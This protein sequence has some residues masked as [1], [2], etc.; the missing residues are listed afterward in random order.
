M[1]H[2]F[3]WKGKNSL[4]DF[5]LWI[6]KLPKITRPSERY[7]E[8]TIPGRAGT[9]ITLEGEDVYERYLKECVV[10]LPSD[11]DLQGILDWLRGNGDVVFSNEIDKAYTGRIAG[12][13]SFERIGNTL[14]QAT[15][16]FFVE[17]FK[18][19]RTPETIS[20]TESGTIY[21]P[22]NITSKPLVSI[23]TYGDAEITIAGKTMTFANVE[24][25]IKV[26]C[27]AEIITTQAEAYNDAAYYYKDDY[28]IFT[29]N[30][31]DKL[32]R[33]TDSGIGSTLVSGGK[34]QEVPDWDG[35]SF[36][37]VWHGLTTGEFWKIPTG[38]STVSADIP[39]AITIDPRWRW[40]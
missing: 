21:N 5:G 2:W 8:V 23:T 6:S 37:Y 31:V 18:K 20:V 1:M 24:N 11:R 26:D 29:E 32:Y 14:Q 10:V 22:G 36:G 16:P 12:E 13:V 27:D 40:V 39:E 17:P 7:E 19:L 35:Q 4:N 9:L 38:S 28:A 15:I 30:S 34:R 3:V 33:F 25:T